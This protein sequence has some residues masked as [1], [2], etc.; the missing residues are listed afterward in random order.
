MKIFASDILKSC[1]TPEGVKEVI[2]SNDKKSMSALLGI[3]GAVEKGGRAVKSD[4]SSS[5]QAA[6][7]WRV[8]SGKEEKELKEKDFKK[9]AKLVS[10]FLN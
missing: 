2:D 4:E 8:L 7:Y 10:I 9:I 6:Y 3:L 5:Q 1:S